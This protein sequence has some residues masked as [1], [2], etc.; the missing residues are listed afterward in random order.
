ME[1]NGNE[2]SVYVNEKVLLNSAHRKLTCNSCHVGFDPEEIPHKENIQPIDCK[3]CHKDAGVKHPFHPEIMKSAGTNGKPN[4]SCK[5]CHG[6]HNVKS[7]DS[8]GSKWSSKNLIISCGNCHK[9]QKEEFTKSD[10]AKGK[11]SGNVNAPDCISCHKNKITNISATKDSLEL[12]LTQQQLCLSCH[13]D[14]P[15]I[16]ARTTP[17]TGFIKA[18][19]ESV[20]G[21]AFQRGNTNAANCIDCHNSHEIMGPIDPA[22]S[23]NKFNIPQTCGKCHLDISREFQASI[24]GQSLSK[25]NKD[26]PACTDCHGEHNI[27]RHD[28]PNAPVAFAN[29]SKEVCSPC[30]SSVQL[31]EKYGIA[32]DRYKTFSDSYHG[33]ALRGGSLEVA[34]CA[35]CHGVHN[36]KPSY[37]P[38]STI[39]KANLVK[40][41]GSCHPGANVNFTV[42]KIHVTMTKEDEPILYWI[43]NTYIVLII[44]IISGML[45]HNIFDFVK[46]TKIKKLIQSGM[47]VPEQTG[48]GLYLRMTL[49]ERIQHMALA[50]SFITLV[51]TGFMLH[52]PDAWWVRHIRDLSSDA[53]EYRSI[54]HRVAAVMLVLVSIYH[55]FYISATDRG[56]R[57]IKDLLPK[58]EDFIDAINMAKF[59]FGISK[60]KPKLDRFS[61]IEKAEYWAL[62]WGTVVMTAT[63]VIMWFDNTF[64]GLFTKLGWDIARTIH[65]FEAW[66]AFL[67]IVVWHFYFVIFSPSV[68]PM[69]LSW[70]TGKIP[71][72]EMREEHAK[73]YERILKEQNENRDKEIKG[74]DT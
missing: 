53:F 58:Y 59:N 16:R 28:D 17:S 42:G 12:K 7:I 55:I 61:Y 39:N 4:V 56:R 3:S 70:I 34:N 52:F 63:G 24:H 26:A 1:K 27:L 40:T 23:I 50:I 48:Y 66:L 22:S 60:N 15:E 72:E 29:V 30:H 51:I 18:Y 43:A 71:E 20:H 25:G 13:L 9:N 73:E 11:L 33:L 69:N 49:D 10:H 21:I 31:A 65:Y 38:T 36:I 47:L 68:Y 64:I 2:V 45:I 46:K 44:V 35:S 8:A 19:E 74:D 14:D 5:N 57:L 62:I 41:C 37:D 67:A 32:S 6:T 54:L